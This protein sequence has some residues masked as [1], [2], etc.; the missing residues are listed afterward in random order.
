MTEE[1][2]L[3][4]VR[5][6]DENYDGMFFYAVK[7]TGIFC[8]PSCKSKIPKK[9]NICFFETADD[10]EKA[11]FRP[12]KR[13][14]SDLIDYEPMKEIAEDIKNKIDEI[15]NSDVEIYNGLK[16]FGLTQRRI[17]DVFKHE[18]GITPKEYM[19]LLKLK[20]AARLIKN[21]D[22]KII[23]IAYSIGFTNLP[24]FNR[25]FKCH[26]GKTPTEYRKSKA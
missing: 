3:N 6:N 19:D 9:E 24:T 22:N 5:N 26:T 17:T 18:Y 4:A 10:A 8:R 12:C 21:T 13:C 11:G 15:Y 16:D 23:D 7:T 20:E 2:M 14:R 1:E 25:F